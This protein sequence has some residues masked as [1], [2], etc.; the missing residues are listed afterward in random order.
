[1]EDWWE[2]EQRVSG[3]DPIRRR[4]SLLKRRRH[5]PA[6]F[7]KSRAPLN[8]EELLI[9][10]QEEQA[11]LFA[12]Y[13]YLAQKKSDLLDQEPLKKEV[14]ERVKESLLP[15]EEKPRVIQVPIY[16]NHHGGPKSTLTCVSARRCIKLGRSL[17]FN[18]RPRQK[19][20]WQVAI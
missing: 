15:I 2:E 10:K 5:P 11:A 17:K 12:K 20:R 4:Q 8:P 1:M 6:H 7:F 9:M 19:F 18:G 3:K 13:L 16:I 14:E